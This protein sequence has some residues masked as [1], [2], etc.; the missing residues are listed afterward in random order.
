MKTKMAAML[1]PPLVDQRLFFQS[2]TDPSAAGKLADGS[3]A[4]LALLCLKYAD[5]FSIR[6]TDP[7][8]I[9]AIWRRMSKMSMTH[10]PFFGVYTPAAQLY[11]R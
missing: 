5:I 3:S 9:P 4:V 10:P 1:L 11:S 8:R 6:V 2:S 7:E